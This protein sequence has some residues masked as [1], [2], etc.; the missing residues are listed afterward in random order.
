MELPSLYN[1]D[2]AVQGYMRH[3]RSLKT[4][5]FSV[6]VTERAVLELEYLRG[7]LAALDIMVEKFTSTNNR[8]DAMPADIKESG[9]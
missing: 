3:A 4:K 2:A 9:L 6:E 1:I 5:G 8:M 7:W